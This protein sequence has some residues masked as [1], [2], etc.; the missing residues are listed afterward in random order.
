MFQA[1]V[2]QRENFTIEKKA[3]TILLD[4]K[5][6]EMDL[7]EIS[8]GYFHII[9]DNQSISAEVVSADVKHK[10]FQIKVNGNIHEVTLKNKM[11]LLLDKMGISAQDDTTIKDI[12]APMPG[13]I[14]DILVSVGDE[15][16]KGN[17]LMVLEAMKMEN[18]LKASGDGI[19]K[20]IEVIKGQSV[21]KNQLLINF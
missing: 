6:F 11:D 18:V 12:K 8:K 14:L 17:Q 3:E 15:I 10:T 16:S 5:E 20:S 4:G 1:K 21:E 9:K 13:L 19:V 2:N 7:S